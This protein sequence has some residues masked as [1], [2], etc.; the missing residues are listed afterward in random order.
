MRKKL[1][2]FPFINTTL[3][4]AFYYIYQTFLVSVDYIGMNLEICVFDTVA[5]LFH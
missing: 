1:S 4:T 5:Y 2:Y 3:A